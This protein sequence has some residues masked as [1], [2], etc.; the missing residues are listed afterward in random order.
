MII[1]LSA[2]F[3]WVG[4][5]LAYYR[6]RGSEANNPNLI[7]NE[8][9]SMFSWITFIIFAFGYKKEKNTKFFKFK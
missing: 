5:M 9:L 8:I 7:S 4:C 2:I 3:Y 6:I 1:I